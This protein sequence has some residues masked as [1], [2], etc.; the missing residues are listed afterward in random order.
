MFENAP[1]R[2]GV[3][4]SG[5]SVAGFVSGSPFRVF[6]GRVHTS[7]R[8]GKEVRT[9]TLDVTSLH[10]RKLRRKQKSRT[11]EELRMK[12]LFAILCVLSLVLLFAAC[13]KEENTNI[14][15][16]TAATDSATTYSSETSATYAAPDTSA[17]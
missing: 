2:R 16:D 5:T 15:T 7:K 11:R 3:F 10:R 6:P 14:G 1:L 8:D 4:I 9:G 13:K 12:K 17:T